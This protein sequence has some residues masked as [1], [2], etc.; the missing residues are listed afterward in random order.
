MHPIIAQVLALLERRR[1]AAFVL[2][3][4]G[5][6]GAAC[7]PCNRD[8]CDA[9]QRRAPSEGGPRLAGVVVS[10]T[11]VVVNGCQECG[12][13]AVDIKAWPTDHEVTTE[14]ELSMVAKGSADSTRSSANGE[15]SLPLVTGLYVV[16]FQNSCFN[17]RVDT[18]ETTTL[19]VRLI[20]GVSS[21]FLSVPGRD[22]LAMK[23]AIFLAPG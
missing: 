4:L 14:S 23:D 21:G 11:D 7:N 17:A 20:N 6:F 9:L 18:K 10:E 1:H 16:C 8:G 22:Q 19:N 5:L 13:A 3:L 15:Y 12:F 2:T